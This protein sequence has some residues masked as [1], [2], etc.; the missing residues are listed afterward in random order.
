MNQVTQVLKRGVAVL[1]DDGP[2]AFAKNAREYLRRVDVSSDGIEISYQTG[3]RVDFEDRWR[4]LR[5]RID[6]DD[7]TLLDI[8]CAEGHL[9]ARFADLGLL[10]IG[11]ERQAHTVA[12][13]RS[14]NA[15]RANLGFLRYEI[16]PETIDDLPAVDVVL[17]LTVY[18]HW[19]SEFGWEAA[20]E[21]LR[22]LESTCEKLF[23]EMPAREMDRPPIQGYSGDS[24]VEYYTAFLETVFDGAVDV[25]HL[26][27]T[28]YKGG[29]RKDVL[30]V[31]EFQR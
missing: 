10:S 9:T 26:G 25:E 2:V 16:T 18:H 22:S 7:A 21:M 28:A 11:V 3:T 1:R 27:T 30:F 6:D 29:D 17:L 13:A 20:E 24:I 15:E 12:N 31:V 23:L 4:L 8:G 14:S 19:V 5:E